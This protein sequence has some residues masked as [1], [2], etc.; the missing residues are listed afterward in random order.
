L[1]NLVHNERV[2]RL[3]SSVKMKAHR[4]PRSFNPLVRRSQ[5]GYSGANQ[6][7]DSVSLR[8]AAELPRKSGKSRVSV[9]AEIR[10]EKPA[11]PAPAGW[12][13][14]LACEGLDL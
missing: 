9:C 3:Q 7:G 8:I 5:P 13:D 1:G 4:R 11:L 2:Y 10:G 12:V 14:T 6:E